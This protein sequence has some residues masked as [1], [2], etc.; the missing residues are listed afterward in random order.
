MRTFNPSF[1]LSFLWDRIHSGLEVN[2]GKL[3]T[4]RGAQ[5]IDQLALVAGHRET[6]ACIVLPGSQGSDAMISHGTA[7]VNE[8]Q[9]I[10]SLDLQEL[11]RAVKASCDTPKNY[12]TVAKLEY[13]LRQY[14]QKAS[15]DGFLKPAAWL[16]PE[17][18]V[19]GKKRKARAMKSLPPQFIGET[20]LDEYRI[21]L[22]EPFKIPGDCRTAV[23]AL[24][25]NLP[26]VTDGLCNQL[27]ERAMTGKEIT[28]FDLFVLESGSERER[29]SRYA[30]HHFVD[31]FSVKTGLRIARGLNAGIKLLPGYDFYGFFTNDVVLTHLNDT[32]GTVQ[33]YFDQYP[34]IGLIECLEAF[35]GFEMWSPQTHQAKPVDAKSYPL[36]YTPYPIIRAI[37][38]RGDLARKLSPEILCPDNWRNWGNDEDLGYRTWRAG[39]YV[40]S[41]TSLSIHEDSFLSTKEHEQVRTEDELTFKHE[42]KAQMEAFIYSKYHT[43]VTTFRRKIF[44]TMLTR[45]D[46]CL[47]ILCSKNLINLCTT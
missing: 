12:H 40:A 10:S 45:V 35:T 15:A 23:L 19:Q 3:V 46:D 26:D 32:I 43:D 9:E 14:I 2:D 28:P 4:Y 27:I 42:A 38:L 13:A 33:S 17:I 22:R 44:E 30:S 11:Q 1:K 39:Y 6:S 31:D 34:K 37:F 18:N 36:F 7:F 20:A 8:I 5:R 16:A 24:N 41:S 47:P 21:E 25:R 29:L